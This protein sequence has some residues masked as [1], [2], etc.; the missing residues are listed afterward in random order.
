MY[1]ME[2]VHLK[3]IYKGKSTIIKT[4][5]RKLMTKLI[6]N[7]WF[8]V[9]IQILQLGLKMHMIRTTDFQQLIITSLIAS[10]GIMLLQITQVKAW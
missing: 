3:L 2:W 1:K 6:G 9:H 7:K 4:S 10:L 5:W 8:I